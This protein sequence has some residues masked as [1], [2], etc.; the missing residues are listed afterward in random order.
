[1]VSKDFWGTRTPVGAA[2]PPL[3]FKVTQTCWFP[4]SDQLLRSG[5]ASTTFTNQGGQV[6]SHE[7]K[8]QEL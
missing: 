1:M 5:L 6:T 2:T 7:L 3:G 8:S 4:S